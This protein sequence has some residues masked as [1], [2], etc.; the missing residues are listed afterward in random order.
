M[1]ANPYR[2]IKSLVFDHVRR[3]KGRVDYKELTADVMAHFPNSKWKKTHWAWYRYQIVRGRFRKEFSEEVRRALSSAKRVTTSEVVSPD[4]AKQAPLLS[5]KEAGVNARRY[6]TIKSLVFDHVRRQKGRVDYKELTA[7][8]M[9][10]FPNSKWKKTHWAWYRYQIVNGR[11]KEEFSEEIRQALSSGKKVTPSKVPP[12]DGGK[13]TPSLSRGPAPRDREVKRIG[14]EILSHVRF[15]VTEIAGDDLGKRFKLNR[16]VLSRLLRD[17]IRVKRAIK[18]ILWDS[19]QK[20]CQAC[21]Q[22][23]ASLKGVEIHR[24]DPNAGYTV[25]NCELLCRECHQELSAG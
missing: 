12:H 18:K 10:H 25:A 21:G 15:L 8:V 11:F 3:Q 4:Q 22:A 7:D 5:R 6:R 1:S 23:F 13:E 9:A 24:K 2:T 19:G 17:E 20:A 16:W 14:D